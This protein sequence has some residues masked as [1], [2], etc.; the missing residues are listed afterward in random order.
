LFPEV[1]KVS[2]LFVTLFSHLFLDQLIAENGATKTSFTKIIF[3]IGL[4]TCLH[5]LTSII[6]GASL[7]KVRM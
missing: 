2:A 6:D 4:P 1:E 7:K 3:E 5:K